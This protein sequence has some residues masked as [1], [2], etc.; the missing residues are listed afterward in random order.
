[1]KKTLMLYALFF[2]WLMP[3]FAEDK[4]GGKEPIIRMEKIIVEDTQISEPA[5]SRLII[6]D[7]ARGPVADGGDLLTTIPGISSARMGGHGVDPVIRG[8]SQNR[9]NILLDGA[10][11]HGG[12]PNR[13]DPPSSYG[14]S[15]TFDEVE[16]T[17][18]SQT[19][20]HG[21]GGSG[22]TVLFKRTTERFTGEERYRGRIGGGYRGNSD[23]REGFVDLA[24]GNT[25]GYIRIIGNYDKSENYEDGDGHSVRSAYEVATGNLI[26]GWTPDNETRVELGYEASNTDDVLFAG[27]GMDSPYTLLDVYRLKFN[28]SL[29]FGVVQKVSGRVSYSDVKHL[30]DN[31]SLRTPSMASMHMRA[32]S[33]SDT[34]SGRLDFEA[35]HGNFLTNFG[36]DYQNNKR[37]AVRYRGNS[38]ALVNIINSYLWPD[39][40][41]QTIGL[42][43]ESEWIMSD[44]RRMKFGL[45]YDH[46]RATADKADRS[47][48]DT[49]GP[50]AKLSASGLYSIY[51]GRSSASEIENNIGG[52]VRFE[53]DYLQGRGTFYTT[54]SRSVR[55]ADATERYMASNNNSKE[56]SRWIGNPFL[57]P[58]KHHQIEIGTRLKTQSWGFDSSVYYDRVSDFILRTRDHG[59][60]A[61]GNNATIYRN[62]SA[63]LIG[64]EMSLN[65]YWSDHLVS[66]ISLAYVYGENLR[67]DR[68]LAQI[69]PLEVSVTTDYKK[70]N[71][72]VGGKILMV[73]NQSRVD[74][75]TLT[76]SGLDAGKTPGFSVFE[77]YGSYTLPMGTKIKF[78]VDNLFDKTYA[79]HLN[80]SNAFDV[81]QVQ[82]N[83]PGRS[84]WFTMDL[85]F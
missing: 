34:L 52:M 59:A 13:M 50:V 5:K 54:L 77:L 63:Y 65:R 45:R 81:D 78:G 11:V 28:R 23:G 32:P 48:T 47:P 40:R 15:E 36:I 19:V 2:L 27:S 29:S 62:V 25:Q 17:K 12:C 8:Q 20:Q 3:V 58:E 51:Y 16:V 44:N 53:Q 10:Y 24:A 4:A 79:K 64:G 68:P 6:S 18:G 85:T 83:E 39:T 31:Y 71:W 74:D 41:L 61:T 21:G 82:V 46:V 55:T 43:G 26:L 7:R 84:I 75:D 14:S 30:M 1:M 67:E 69:P 72:S 73:N 66:G 70:S 35:V 22:G 57:A 33:I 37:D 56:S 9:L 80:L 49:M 76:G 38:P 60:S 42:Y